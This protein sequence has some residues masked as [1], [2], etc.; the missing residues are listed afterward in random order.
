MAQPGDFREV[1]E[2]R[3]LLIDSSIPRGPRQTLTSK[4]VDMNNA[5]VERLAYWLWQQQGMPIGSPD[6]DWFLAEELLKRQYKRSE[7]STRDMP[8]AAFVMGKWTS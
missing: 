2:A 6:T 1:D 3:T 7:P 8:L 4:G 5:Q